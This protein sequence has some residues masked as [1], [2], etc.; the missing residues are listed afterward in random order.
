MEPADIFAATHI[1]GPERILDLIHLNKFFICQH[2]LRE[3][4]PTEGRGFCM[5]EVDHGYY[6]RYYYKSEGGY[7][8]QA[9]NG[10]GDDLI[11]SRF[12]W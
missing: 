11:G 3:V 7:E 12:W 1:L 2:Y 5:D 10:L 9:G 8:E 6:W 4:D